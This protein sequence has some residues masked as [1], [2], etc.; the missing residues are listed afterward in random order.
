MDPRMTEKTLWRCSSCKQIVPWNFDIC[1]NCGTSRE[2]VPDPNFAPEISF[3]PQCDQCGYL[4]IGLPENRCPECGMPF[5]P[6]KKDTTRP[7]PKSS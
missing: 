1:W 7:L 5:D 6:S 4:L 3:H 2:G